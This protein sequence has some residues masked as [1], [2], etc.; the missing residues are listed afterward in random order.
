MVGIKQHVIYTTYYQKKCGGTDDNNNL[1][2]LCPNCHRMVHN[3]SNEITKEMLLDNSLD[4]VFKQI[5]EAYHSS[6]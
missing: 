4:K 2:I 5:K 6:N 3:H 1:I